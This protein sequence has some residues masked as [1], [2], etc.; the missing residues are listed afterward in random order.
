MNL[1]KLRALNWSQLWRL[2]AEKDLVTMYGTSLADQDIFNGLLKQHPSL[3]H[4]LP[5]QWNLQ[6]SDNTRSEICYSSGVHDLNII[7][8]NSP[9]KLNVK[10]KN[11]AYFRNH[12]LTFLQYDGNLLRRELFDCNSTLAKHSTKELVDDKE[13]IDDQDDKCY[14]LEKA[15]DRIYRTHPFYLDYDETVEA[16]AAAGD[17]TLI[18]QLSMDRLHMVETLCN[19]WKGPISL[20]LYLSDAE[21]D[22]FVKFTQ[23]SKVLNQRRNVGYHIVYKEGVMLILAVGNS[24]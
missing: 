19:Q 6:L 2:V 1:S 20:S 16:E 4:R 15:R 22:Q 18:A 13:N 7:H 5:C 21:A 12:Y 9:K 14:E 24:I 17:V 8:F 3:V 23:N 11:V 10:N